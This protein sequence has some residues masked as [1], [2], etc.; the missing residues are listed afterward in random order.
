MIDLKL[1]CVGCAVAAPA[2]NLNGAPLCVSCAHKAIDRASP[3]PPR[4][5][6]PPELVERR[7]AI[8]RYLREQREARR[9]AGVSMPIE[10]VA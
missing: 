4:A 2:I 6:V 10:A 1:C 7:H 9:A 3:P 5:P 8:G